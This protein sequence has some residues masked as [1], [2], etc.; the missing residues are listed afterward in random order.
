MLPIILNKKAGTFL[1]SQMKGESG[2]ALEKLKSIRDD[3][4]IRIVP[5]KKFGAAVEAAVR[6][7]PDRI[8]VGGGDGSVSWA[9]SKLVGTGIAM[10]I[11]PVGTFNLFARD[12]HLPLD[13]NKACEVLATGTV[14]EVDVG[15]VNGHPFVCN[16]V[17]GFLPKVFLKVD[18]LRHLPWWQR[19]GLLMWGF[20]PGYLKYRPRDVSHRIGSDEAEK[21]KSRFIIVSN[22]RYK[23]EFGLLPETENLTDRCLQTFISTHPNAWSLMKGLRSY[24]AGEWL[25]DPDLVV[26]TSHGFQLDLPGRKKVSALLDGEPVKL[27]CPL[28]FKV[29]A[30][31][32]SVIVPKAEPADT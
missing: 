15:D 25:S 11:L 14:Q 26:K 13:L 5:T 19:M 24:F 21:F 12:L 17:Y 9:A 3:V 23:E 10:G 6:E 31:S 8:I 4:D 20:I 1:R 28:E 7:G 32:L 2:D 22:N 16:F 18:A 27:T 29:Q 30:G